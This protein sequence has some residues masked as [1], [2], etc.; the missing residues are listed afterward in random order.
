MYAVVKIA[1]F[2]YLV[3]PGEIVTV[4]RLEGEPGSPVRFDDV[5]MVRTEDQAI[6]GRPTVPDAYV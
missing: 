3:K 4:P 1:G 6:I 5:L 2:Q